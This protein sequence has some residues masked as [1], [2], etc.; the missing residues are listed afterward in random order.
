MRRAI[1]LAITTSLLGSAAAQDPAPDASSGQTQDAPDRRFTAERVFDLEY[2]DGPAVSPDGE[3]VLYVRKSMDR[4]AD[5][6]VGDLWELDLE[7]GTH[8]PLISGQSSVSPPVWS[9]SGDR[10]LYLTSRDGRPELRVH[11]ADTNDSFAIAQLPEAPSAP[12]WSPD[13]RT[14][15]FAM[16]VREDAEP[17]TT[18]PKAPEGAEW[19]A[20]VRLFDKVTFRFDG[21]GYLKR[22]D[23]HVF[24]VPAEGG[25]PRQATFGDGG[26]SGP[27][28]M[29]DD[30]LIVVGNP[31]DDRHLDAIE[32]DLFAVDL[33]TRERTRLT[34][35][36]GPDTSP[37]VAPGGRLIAYAG[38]DDRRVS[39]QQ[40][41]LYVMRPDGSGVR[42][43]TSDYDR[44]VGG[45]SWHP[46]GDSV[47]AQVE[48]D[49]E[50][51]L[52]RIP[53]RGAPTILATDV[54]GTSLG[55][56]YG[57]GSFTVGGT[58]RA[59]VYAYTS[60]SALRPADVA[61]IEG[62]GRPELKTRLN[63]DTLAYLDL[64][65]IEEISVPSRADGLPIEAWVALPPGFEADG[66]YPLI[67][68]IHGGPFA[69]YGPTFA[70]EIQRFAA[71]G[72]VVVYA[73]PR[74]S[75]G[76]GEDFAREI[77]LAYPGQDYD[78]L[79][80]VVS[81]LVERDYVDPNRLFVTGGSGGGVLTAWIVGT[82]DRFQ[83]AAT[84]KPVINWTSMALAADIGPYVARHWMQAMPWEEP[85]RY[86]ELSPISLAG[87]VT[88]PTLVMVGE[89]D[90]R[91]PA[92]EAEQF[93]TAL[94]LQGVDTALVRVPG[95]SHSI[96][97]RPSNL[98]AK[99][100]NILGWFARYDPAK[101]A[102]A[103][104]DKP[105]EPR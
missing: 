6:V 25:T 103:E 20:P 47:V 62:G 61:V 67:L 23:T 69:M 60:A 51:S 73:N 64:A 80:S 3:T 4:L 94:H 36:D 98:I 43:L 79:M 54:G 53:L 58:G 2:A 92:W 31:N 7:T 86:W 49:G 52:V 16:A 68:E 39:Y 100:D 93:Y 88:T 96:A 14:I 75:T 78:D 85:E 83:A 17:L 19:A 71:E 82:T 57:S 84:I 102:D 76:Y 12:V 70:A 91:T 81:S 40:T 29:T 8:R 34:T 77:D 90:W 63:E 48:T 26:F 22:G 27:A 72:Y 18:A 33:A 56:P 10:F 95:A 30:R 15:A 24:T 45:F 99:V 105:A 35:R 87:N 37:K 59:P 50:T 101:A 21:Q 44:S 74:G 28:W 1:F 89:E 104:G 13:G 11:Y 66:T 5:R 9:P 46:D 65:K 55:R 32:S 38:Y 42:N 41:D 97:S